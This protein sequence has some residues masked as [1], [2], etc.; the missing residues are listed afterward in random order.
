MNET[1]HAL[2]L[3]VVLLYVLC[4]V[5]RLAEAEYRNRAFADLLR[6]YLALRPA[7]RLIVGVFVV[8]M[9]LRGG[10]KPTNE[11]QQAS[12]PLPSAEEEMMIEEAAAALPFVGGSSLMSLMEGGETLRLS[13]NQYAAGFALL[14]RT[15]TNAAWLTVP[16]NAVVHAPWARYGLAED[17]FWLPATNWGFVLG[18]NAVEGAHVSGSGTLSFDPDMPKGS[19]RAAAMPDGDTI[20]FLAPLQGSL[21]T[22]PPQGRFWHAVTPSN[23]VLMTW[24]DLFA[25]RDTNSP[26]TFQAELFANGDF[27]YRYAFANAPAPTNFVVGAQRNGCG[28]TYALNDTNRLANG[29]ELRWRA[30]GALDPEVEDH[31]GDGLSTYDEVM[32]HGTDPSRADSDHDGLDDAAELANATDPLEPDGDR[33]GL[34]DGI[35]PQPTVWNDPNATNSSDGLTYWYKVQHGLDP[36]ADNSLDSDSDG[37]PDWKELLAGTSTNNYYSTPQNDDGSAKLFDA[38]FTLAADLPCPVVLNVGGHTLVLRQAGCR[39]LTLKEGVAHD[40]VLT[41]SRPCSVSLSVSLSSPYAALQSGSGAFSGG[42]ALCG[43]APTACGFVAQPT[44]GIEPGRVCFHTEA[45]KTVAAS[46]SPKMAGSCLWCWYGGG[47]SSVTGRH[48]NISWDAGDGYVYLYFTAA[49][50]AQPRHAYRAV[51]KCAAGGADTWCDGH[52]CEHWFC[53]CDNADASDGDPCGFHGQNVSVC[54]AAVCPRHHCPYANCPP[55]W[56]H[57]HDTWYDDCDA[58]WCHWHDRYLSECAHEWYGAGYDPESGAGA[59]DPDPDPG[60][61]VFSSCDES[62]AAVNNDDDDRSGTPDTEDSP[63]TRDNDLVAVRPLG[64]FDGR[65]C[66]CPEHRA[67]SAESAGLAASSQRLALWADAFKT[68]AFGDTVRAGQPV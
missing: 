43:G 23:S 68:N 1:R 17:T 18:T 63:V 41:A 52:G 55:G 42:A 7:H 5:V 12:Y 45:P 19:P 57:R 3:F 20:P 6:R 8:I 56:C 59:P 44:L 30:I 13:S 51:T 58:W 22:A 29:L 38:T 4:G 60:E 25:G 21:G 49:G 34:A 14:P 62:L 48:A 37:W 50:A 53:A 27:A 40:L 47:I 65:C 54:R 11:Q 10:S 2:A 31:D 61:P 16:S 36:E 26:V 15:S 24:Q 39:T 35:D 67:Q 28:E 32:T 33:D 64:L 46:V 9:C 66:P